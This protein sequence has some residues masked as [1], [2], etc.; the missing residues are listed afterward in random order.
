MRE[1]DA[2]LGVDIKNLK[3]MVQGMRK[4]A[5]TLIEAKPSL[6]YQENFKCKQKINEKIEIIEVN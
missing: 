3:H 2:N 4:Q 6:F 5:E 1:N